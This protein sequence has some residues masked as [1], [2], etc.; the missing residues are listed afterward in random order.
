M[1]FHFQGIITRFTHNEARYMS[2]AGT[3]EMTYFTL[4]ALSVNYF[5]QLRIV[6]TLRGT[7]SFI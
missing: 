5:I 4:A 2:V 1:L 6:F 3:H 7:H